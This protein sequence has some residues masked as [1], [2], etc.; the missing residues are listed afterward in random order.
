M[1]LNVSRKRKSENKA[2]ERTRRT[3]IREFIFS[4]EWLLNKVQ[5]Y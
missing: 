1:K 2:A 5:L 4:K 3:Y